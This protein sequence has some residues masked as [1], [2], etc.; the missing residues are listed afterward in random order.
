MKNLPVFVVAGTHSGCGKTSVTLGLMA[1]LTSKGYKVQG[2][3][4]GP[5]F[6]D[7][8]HHRS[9]TGRDSHNLD[10]WML[11]EMRSREIF[12]RYLK[13][14]DI[15]IIE[16]VMGLFDGFSPKQE[17]GSTAH[18][19]KVLD[20]PVVLV[21]DASSMARSV[22]ALVQGFLNFDKSLNIKG[23][24]FNRVGSK[25]HASILI[26]AIE[27]LDIKV[28]GALPKEDLILIP[29]RH[30]GL[31]TQQDFGLKKDM[32]SSLCKWIGENINVDSI[33]RDCVS[34]VESLDDDFK[35]DISNKARVA[36]AM[37]N[38]FC[39]YYS[40]NLRILQEAGA[41]LC[42]F[43]PLRDR[44]LPEG[45]KGLYIGGGYPELY[46][47]VLS[48]N[49]QMLK[50]I[51]EF[52]DNNGVI[53]AECG[54]FMFLTKGIRDLKGN[55]YPMVGIFPFECAMRN[56]FYALGYRDVTTV[57]NSILGPEGLYIKGHEFHYSF[58][59]KEYGLNQVKRIY[60]AKGSRD[61]IKEGF[62]INNTLG[63]YIHLHFG[64]NPE[65]T[66]N[67]INTCEKLW[68]H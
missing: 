19:A 12:L 33:L 63:S 25:R 16:G 57:A 40:E 13:G 51:K 5:D 47:D 9:V 61:F 38:A 68:T 14:A 24:I 28:Y 1:Y 49:K 58:I 20:V 27:D 62:C 56:R 37:D 60:L 7:P 15:A 30:L 21:V 42:F 35:Q 48:E 17:V 50:C 41:E 43:S 64:S 32:L 59:N 45:V 10:T 3:K 39:F 46:C 54:G 31:V 53:Y 36:V 2:Y 67:F 22:S 6:I 34:H 4:V 23:V 11:G 29:T 18:M 8:G 65:A 52:S 66:L 26:E 55:F 44:T